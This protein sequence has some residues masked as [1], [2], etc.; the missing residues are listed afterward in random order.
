MNACLNTR[1]AMTAVFDVSDFLHPLDLSAR[2]HLEG[3]PLLQAAVKRY[4]SSV[5]DRREHL[6]LLASAVRLGPRQ[7][8]AIYRMLPPICDAFGIP[9][10]ELYLMRGEANAM[11]MGH[12]RPAIVIFNQLL[13]D[14]AED[15]IQAVLAHECG[16]ILAEHIL[17]RQMARAIAGAG[18]AGGFLGP[19]LLKAAT[20]LATT[21]L[22]A[23]LI[24]WYRKSELTADRAAAGYLRDAEPMQRAL[25]HIMGLPKWM[26]AEVSHTALLEQAAEFDQSADSSW[27]NRYLSRGIEKSAVTHPLP[28]LRVRELAVWAQS[29]TFQQLVGI[30]KIGQPEERLGCAQCGRQLAADWRF[31][32]RCG[33]PVPQAAVSQTGGES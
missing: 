25:F 1:N 13:E 10:P 27:W 21:Q 30:A 18:Q 14:L 12:S 33:A 23:A 9:E 8:P 6:W 5:T 17:Y 11:T 26:P 2:Q 22:Q 16:H 32:Q 20:S 29:D 15:E 4:L 3:I 28:A 19:G 31:C 7:M 24:N